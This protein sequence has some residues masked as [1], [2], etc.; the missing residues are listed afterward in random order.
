MNTRQIFNM[1]ILSLFLSITSVHAQSASDLQ[2]G[3][4]W[5]C[6]QY[7]VVPPYACYKPFP[8]YIG[9]NVAYWEPVLLIE[10][11]KKP[12]DSVI[13][14]FIPGMSST[15]QSATQSLMPGVSSL[16]SGSSR[17]ADDTNT[18]MNETHVVGFPW[19]DAFSEAMAGAGEC[20]TSI[21]ANTSVE[22]LSELDSIE[23]RLGLMEAM[24]PKSLASA[25]IG[26]MCAVADSVAM[27]NPITADMCMGYWG[28]TYPRRGFLTHQSEV[29]GSAADAFRGASIAGIIPQTPHVVL[30]P[31][32]WQPNPTTDKLQEIWPNPG[33]C[34]NIG[35]N[36]MLWESG[37]TS[38]TG[39]YVW[40]YWKRKTCCVW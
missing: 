34:M 16:S 17:N 31:L 14:S 33:M 2:G 28:P 36:P 29:V 1:F 23:W 32:L 11:V 37:K 35:Q 6:I 9:V 26:P 39:K 12:G 30:R 27:L 25:A 21:E 40:I 3:I 22:Y 19:G 7:A 15:L 38:I 10:T 8:P 4:S 20:P 24:N 13:M 18:Q 5:A